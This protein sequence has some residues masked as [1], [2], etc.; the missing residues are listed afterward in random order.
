MTHPIMPVCTTAAQVNAML[1]C[2]RDGESYPA[3]QRAQARKEFNAIYNKY[4][5]ILEAEATPAIPEGKT[6]TQMEALGYAVNPYPDTMFGP[7]MSAWKINAVLTEDYCEAI[8]NY[9]YATG[10]DR[11]FTSSGQ[12]SQYLNDT[13][14]IAVSK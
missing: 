8:D 13:G 14:R 9:I 10:A 4:R 7:A 2:L 1:N 6:Q 12:L 11:R 3:A 5:H